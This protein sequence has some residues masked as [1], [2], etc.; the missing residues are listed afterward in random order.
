MPGV[1][2]YTNAL[3]AA[4]PEIVAFSG[5]VDVTSVVDA[6]A[7]DGSKSILLSTSSRILLNQALALVIDPVKVQVTST[8]SFT[9]TSNEGIGSRYDEIKN[10][11]DKS[12]A[13]NAS[14]SSSNAA[15][16][17]SS[18]SNFMTDR[19]VDLGVL[20]KTKGVSVSCPTASAYAVLAGSKSFLPPPL[21][22]LSSSESSSSST[23][24]AMIGGIV[25]GI[26]FLGL[27]VCFFYRKSE[28][29]MRR[30]IFLS[31]RLSSG[32][33]Y[34][35]A[36]DSSAANQE[37]PMPQK[38]TLLGRLILSIRLSMGLAYPAAASTDVAETQNPMP[39]KKGRLAALLT[40]V[41]L[42]MGWIY[43]TA[44]DSSVEDTENPVG[45][46]PFRS[47]RRLFDSVRLS[48]SRV[49]G[50]Q[51]P[52]NQENPMHNATNMHGNNPRQARAG[53]YDI[54]E[55]N[56]DFNGGGGGSIAMNP[57]QYTSTRVPFQQTHS[58][59]DSQKEAGGNEICL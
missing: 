56:I 21:T 11:L 35:G 43:P 33:I 31:T 42:S 20:P 14:S 44:A 24:Y 6:T 26:V 38:K 49:F 16:N 51:N 50:I 41:R 25:G 5:K 28:E 3:E 1:L 39:R 12:C 10:D 46:N 23:N 9:A 37:N 58:E 29:K 47:V 8:I 18:I 57:L 22:Q 40:S 55:T 48:L 19:L 45:V 32:I 13:V 52:S 36:A 4:A 17:T 53:R 30:S 54:R 2:A 7:N 15:V 27:L 59:R 34:P